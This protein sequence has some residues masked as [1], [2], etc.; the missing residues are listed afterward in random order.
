MF[1]CR[2]P[3]CIV[4]PTTLTT[5]CT[6][7]LTTPISPTPLFTHPRPKIE[8]AWLSFRFHMWNRSPCSA[9]AQSLYL[10]LP[11][12]QLP[13]P[14]HHPHSWHTLCLL[15]VHLGQYR[16][17]AL[18]ISCLRVK[19]FATTRSQ[20]PDLPQLIS[21]PFPHLRHTPRQPF[22]PQTISK[23]NA[24]ATGIVRQMSR[25]PHSFQPQPPT[26]LPPHLPHPKHDSH[27]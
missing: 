18:S 16:T 4:H 22:P 9:C 6:P 11:P 27:W 25:P 21:P 17:H 13:C 26:H 1:I 19:T 24:P 7:P 3:C 2:F 10:G 14:F 20:C 23:C 8:P 12:A 5:A 15:F